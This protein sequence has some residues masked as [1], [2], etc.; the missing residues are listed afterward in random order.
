MGT[1]VTPMYANLTLAYLEKTLYN[2]KMIK[3]TD[4]IGQHF[5]TSWI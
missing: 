2:Q 4:S 5:E 3:Y 1:N